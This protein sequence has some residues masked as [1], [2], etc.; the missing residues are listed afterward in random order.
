MDPDEDADPAILIID[1]QDANKK[2]ILKNFSAYYF[3]KVSYMC[4]A[5]LQFFH[6]LSILGRATDHKRIIIA[7]CQ[8]FKFNGLIV[9]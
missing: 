3:L 8:V 2:L 4:H 7:T 9:F 1:L 6:R 5:R